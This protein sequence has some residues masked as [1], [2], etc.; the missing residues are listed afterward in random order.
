MKRKRSK[1]SRILI[2]QHLYILT[3]DKWGKLKVH[4]SKLNTVKI[5]YINK[6][7]GN[8]F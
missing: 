1:I 2:A 8:I 6:D 5:L 3:V 7:K 4:N